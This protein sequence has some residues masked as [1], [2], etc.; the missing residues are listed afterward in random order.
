MSFFAGAVA[1]DDRASLPEGVADSLAHALSRYPADRPGMM[2][3]AGRCLVQV[4]LPTESAQCSHVDGHGNITLL[5]GE[6]LFAPGA[7]CAVEALHDA[8]LAED[9]SKLREARGSYCGVHWNARKRRIELI[10]DKLGLR[11]IYFGVENGVAYFSTALRVF[12]TMSVLTAEMDVRAVAEIAALGYPLGARSPYSAVRTIE[13]GEVVG[14]DAGGVRARR[15]WRWDRL[16]PANVPEAELPQAV[17]RSFIAAIE[18]RLG[19]ERSAVAGLSGG[20]DSRCVVAGLASLGA[21]VHT[22]NFA[23]AGSED[24]AL[25]RL[26]SVALGTRHF[27]APSG[28]LEFWDRMQAAHRAWLERT[29]GDRP[30]HTHR[31]WSGDGGSCT[32]GHIYITDNIVALMRD[33]QTEAAIDAYLARNR[34]GLPRKL[35]ARAERDRLAGYPRQGIRAE[36]DRLQDAD[37]ARRIHLY[38]LVNGQRRLHAKHYENIDLRRFELVTPFFDSD[39]IELIVTSPIEGFLHHRFYNRWLHEF[40]PAV[41]SVPWQAYP[42]HAPCPLPKPEGLRN[43]W[44]N[45][46]DDQA[47][48]EMAQRDLALADDLLRGSQLPRHLF[49][50][51][52]LWLARWLMSFNLGDYTHVIKCAAIFA[53]Y[54][55]SSPAQANPDRTR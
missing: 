11:P 52:I 31:L 53:R 43:Q 34:I 36:L 38:L 29:P 45:W 18:R 39:M 20:L 21:D 26:A 50:R 14:I 40:Q 27:E 1:I 8:M 19:G 10:A 47:S 12:E 24:L 28:P 2:R 33:G 46:Y 22:L 17:H 7:K 15:Y 41:A 32:L 3:D 55:A 49:N 5:A 44:D 54:A 13:A 6:P 30:R 23:P 4:V 48:A 37:A 51:H 9:E 25:G 42:D 35:F 16:P